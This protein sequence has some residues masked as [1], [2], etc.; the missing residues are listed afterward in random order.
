MEIISEKEY[1]KNQK[2]DI[3]FLVF[4]FLQHNTYLPWAECIKQVLL[5]MHFNKTVSHF[6]WIFLFCFAFRF[7][8]F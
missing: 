1:P 5:V 6:G 8:F 7:F 2:K 3:F 4:F